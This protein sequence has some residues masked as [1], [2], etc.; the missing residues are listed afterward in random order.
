MCYTGTLPGGHRDSTPQM[1]IVALKKNECQ[2]IFFKIYSFQDIR[3]NSFRVPQRSK[4]RPPTNFGWGGGLDAKWNRF[5][6]LDAERTHLTS[7]VRIGQ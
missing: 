6:P 1:K 3:N 2:Q 4:F 5:L 7:F